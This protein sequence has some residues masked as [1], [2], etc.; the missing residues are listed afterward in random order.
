[1]I[2][3]QE[4]RTL[5]KTECEEHLQSLDA[6]LLR[7]EQDPADSTTLE[8][9]FRDAHSLKGAARMLGVM[10]IGQIAH[11]FE[12]ILGAARHG[13]VT[14][15]SQTVDRLYH[16]LDAIR[17][18]VHE[19]VS[20]E[21]SE[22]DLQAILA[23]LADIEDALPADSPPPTSPEK[24]AQSPVPSASHTLPGQNGASELAPSAPAP[25]PPAIKYQLDTIRVEARKLDALM[26]QAGEL[27]VTQLRIARRLAEVEELAR[28]WEEWNRVH[29]AV[30]ASRGKTNGT[31]VNGRARRAVPS[32][33]RTS[34][35]WR[36]MGML[37]GRL[38]ESIY[39]DSAR[40][41]LITN[42]IES[43]IQSIRMLPLS[44]LF[45]LFP[46]MVRDLA[47]E[48]G[49]EVQLLIEGGETRADKRILEEMKDPLMHMLRNSIDHGL[50][51]PDEREQHGKPRQ[52]TI[53]LRAYQTTNNIIIEVADD[54]RG[55]NTEAIARKAVQRGILHPDEL[56]AMSP[57]Q[58]HELIFASGLSTSDLITDISG[59]GVGMDV[60]RANVEQLKGTIHVESTPSQGTTFR[61]RLPITV[62]TTRVL[63]VAAMERV[64]ALPIEFVH[65]TQMVS[66][67]EIFTIE[68]SETVTIEG[69]P[70]S[71]A[72]LA[73]ILET[74][75]VPSEA[76]PIGQEQ[77][78]PC[79]IL[80]VNGIEVGLLVNE[81]LGVQEVVLKPHNAI[82]QR[83]RNVA[84]ATILGA[85]EVCMVLNA[86]DLV[87]SVQRRPAHSI[88]T[89]RPTKKKR[90]LRLLL[91]ED[92]I[93]TRTQ[94]KRILEAAGYEVVTAVDGLDAYNKL[95]TQTFD[96]L[97]S[98]VEMPNMDGLTLT[99]KVRQNNQFQEL[100]IILITSLASEADRKRGI[101]V[102]ANAYITKSAFDQELLLS[103]L[104]RL[105]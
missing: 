95:N 90:Q 86:H 84:G 36:Q 77:A 9:M 22:I 96:A 74:G 42:E 71:I 24:T 31:A 23:D 52:A 47:R 32:D 93:T 4:L 7:L 101:E 105:I 78:F 103:T 48:Q 39:L 80:S 73:D 33:P 88:H 2:E 16:G 60:V 104:R 11:R 15:T 29:A 21:A 61:V 50:E 38:R 67:G 72:R 89:Q 17:K 79:V 64:Y 6:G 58:I 70:I 63:V 8:Q 91:A 51:P 26:T 55:L 10:D 27:S 85:G 87:K 75:S 97:I 13:K 92:S 28:L 65:T 53:R 45:N 3:D 30:G 34:Q 69:K 102:G 37:L 66:E 18:L 62:A 49:K 57:A 56:A 12:D 54:G 68:G 20:G 98:D 41:N 43:G 25:P 100:P 5:F 82:L 94:E 1:M 14:L 19:A 99:A 35:R 44:T 81:L 46:R 40:L 83:V 76:D 59:R